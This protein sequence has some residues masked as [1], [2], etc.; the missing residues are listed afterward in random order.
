M[1]SGK[2]AQHNSIVDGLHRFITK[3][4]INCS[5]EAVNSL[6]DTRQRPGDFYISIFDER[7]DDAFFDFSVIHILAPLY[8]RRASKSQLEASKIRYDFKMTK[9][10]D[11]GTSFKPLV[12]ESTGGWHH[13]SFKYL[14]QIAELVVAH[15][16]LTTSTA[17]N[18][19]LTLASCRLQRNQ[20]AILTRRYLGL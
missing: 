17:L 3:H 19:M 8:I 15:S 4:N 20:G 5:K 14:K 13:S 18:L 11:Q 12:L 7:E 10:H 6:N 9:Y 16:R 1:A 2:I